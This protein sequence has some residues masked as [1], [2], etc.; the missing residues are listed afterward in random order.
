MKTAI[1]IPDA[2]FVQAEEIARRH[3]KSRSQVYQEAIAEYVARRDPAA[4]TAAYDAV[5]DALGDA[6]GAD[7]WLRATAGAALGRSEW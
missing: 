7:P 1:S 3:G 6:A 5:A 4:V 2:L